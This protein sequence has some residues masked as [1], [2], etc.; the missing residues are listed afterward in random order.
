M[1]RRNWLELARKRVDRFD[2]DFTLTGISELFEQQALALF[3]PG[4]LITNTY[5]DPFPVT[6]SG[7]SFGGSIGPGVAHDNNGMAIWNDQASRIFTIPQA[8]PALSRWD[9]LILRYKVTPTVP[10]PK[11][12]DPI[13][14]VYLNLTDDFDVIVLPGTPSDTPAYRTKGP[15]DV[16]I[17]GIQVPALA[18]LGTDTTLD[19][20]IQ[21]RAA[22]DGG[23]F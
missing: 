2:L 4:I 23:S 19:L 11:P 8:D 16:I 5:P 6:L 1:L 17:A 12:S 3:G 14:T 13:T 21:E 15:N 10:I 7:T 20:T 22:I 9:L 18:L